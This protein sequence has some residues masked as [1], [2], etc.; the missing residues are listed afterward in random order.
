MRAAPQDT[1]S[2]RDLARIVTEEQSG[3]RETRVA[4][5]ATITTQANDRER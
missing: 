4:D 5:I 2:F 1:V 3:G